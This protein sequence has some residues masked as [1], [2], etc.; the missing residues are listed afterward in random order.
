MKNT[1]L[2]FQFISILFGGEAGDGIKESAKIFGEIL[3]KLGQ[4]VFILMDYPS[5]IRGGHNFSRVVFSTQKVWSHYN[6]ADVIVALN[7]ET[8]EKHLSEIRKGGIIF[9]DKDEIPTPPEI[10]NFGLPMTSLAKELRAPQAFRNAIAIGALSYYLGI[11]FN[12]IKKV[13][14]EI[15]KEKALLDIK[16]AQEGYKRAKKNLKPRKVIKKKKISKLPP[17]PLLTGN[18]AVAKGAVASGLQV[19]IAYPMTPS[20]SILHWLASHKKEYQLKVIQPENEIG[21]I[22]M[23]LGSAFA[24]KK[25]MIG[26]SGGGFALMQEAFSLAGI[27]ETPL[28]AVESQRTGPSTGVPTYTAQSDLNFLRCA[29]H[30]EFPRIILAPGDTEE[31]Y[32]LAAESL[33]LAWKFQVPVILVSDKHLSESLMTTNLA[34]IKKIVKPKLAKSSKDYKR[35][36]ITKDGISPLAFPGQKDFIVKSTSYEHNEFGIT[37]EEPK[38]IKMMQEKRFKKLKEIEKELRKIA[39][40]KIYGKKAAKDLLISWGSTKGQVLEAMH[41]FKKPVKFIQVLC[42][43]PFPKGLTSHLREAKKIIDIE[44]NFEGQLASIIREKT[45]AEI[46]DKILKYDSRTFDPKILAQKINEK[47]TN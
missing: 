15:Y 38:E 17:K 21:V 3:T 16:L 37:T 35:Y 24:G 46:K 13:F 22:N 44:L 26:T 5:L 2:N 8:I 42:I 18:E 6:A 4:E 29:G 10:S 36:R 43:E 41:Y 28:V 1:N 40:F 7:Q 20:T 45:G 23:A 9:Y 25:T 33:N 12:L 30:G 39:T 14:E 34:P 11:E 27:S 19:Y 31:A 47:L 32:F